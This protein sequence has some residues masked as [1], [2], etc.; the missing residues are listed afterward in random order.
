MAG[1]FRRADASRGRRAG[2]PGARPG[3]SRHAPRTG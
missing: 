2:R 1:D 3:V